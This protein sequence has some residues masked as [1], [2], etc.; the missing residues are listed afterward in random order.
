MG[1]TELLDPP[2]HCMLHVCRGEIN[3]AEIRR[4]KS[5]LTF[6]FS[7]VS[8]SDPIRDGGAKWASALQ[9]ETPWETVDLAQEKEHVS[10]SSMATSAMSQPVST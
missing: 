7:F 8:G 1:T 5:L 10:L 9:G 4:T 3:G 6:L 2:W